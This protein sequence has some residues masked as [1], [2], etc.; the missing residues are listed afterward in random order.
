MN[1]Q[2]TEKDDVVIVMPGA[3]FD[4]NTAPEV[5]RRLR[6]KSMPEVQEWSSISQRPITSQAPGFECF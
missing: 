5:E 6:K 4:T 2:V 3:R 1:V